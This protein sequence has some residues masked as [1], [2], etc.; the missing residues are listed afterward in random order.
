MLN[1]FKSIKNEYDLIIIGGGIYGATLLWEATLRGLSAIL[2]EKNDF[3]SATSANSLKIIHGGLRYLQS[4]DLKRIRESAT[5]QNRWLETASHLVLPLPCIIPTY[6]KA[7]NSKLAMFAAFKLYKL[8]C[9]GNKNFSYPPTQSGVILSKEKLH[10]LIPISNRSDITG[11]ALWYDALMYNS[12]RLALEFIL[13]SIEHGAGAFNY[14]EFQ[15]L[16]IRKGCVAG[17]RAFDKISFQKIVICSKTVVNASGPWI[18]CVCD[19]SNTDSRKQRF[20]FAKAINLIIP[21]KISEYAFGLKDSSPPIDDYFQPNRF[22]F[23][24]PWREATIIG[25]WYFK[26]ITYNEDATLTETEYNRCI[27]QIQRLIPGLEV[28]QNEVCFVHSGLVPI[29]FDENNRLFELRRNYSLIDHQREGG[30]DGFISVLGVKYTTARNV[31]ALT[32]DLVLKKLNKKLNTNDCGN[33]LLASGK[34]K[35][36]EEFIQENTKNNRYKLSDY[37]L[38]HLAYN[39]GKN[40][41]HILKLISENSELGEQIPGS[42]EAIK[43]ELTYCLKKESVCHLSD[44]ILRRTGIGTVKKPKNET[45]NFCADFM[46]RDMDWSASQKREEIN[47]LLKFYDRFPMSKA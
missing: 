47:D 41:Y 5:E 39:Y 28:R 4:F 12:E 42:V 35:N 44:F 18:N 37:T 36:I 26:D 8:I 2:V 38:R 20:H 34:I 7:K 10:T 30:P 9:I 29:D 14:L 46:A 43:A 6:Q 40:Y 15:D 19:G 24:V 33:T 32:V 11:G 17:I 23:F 31:A 3:C 25:T 1:R 27:V 13:S 45:I 22:L 16:I 21:R